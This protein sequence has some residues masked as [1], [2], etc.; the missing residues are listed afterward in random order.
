MTDNNSMKGRN[1][2]DMKIGELTVPFINRNST[3]YPTEVGSVK[4]ELV[5]VKQQKDVMLNVARM[6]AQQ[7]YDRIME[8][9]NVLQKQADNIKRRLDVTD[10]VHAAEYQF[11]LVHGKEYWLLYDTDFNNYRLSMSGPNDW[12]AGPP[13]KYNYITKVKWL[14]DYTWVEIS[15][16]K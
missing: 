12:V 8:L 16:D 14:G 5:P 3:E 1:S 7:E 10:A 13:Q 15:D 4:F 9:V 11:N 2:Q 6:H